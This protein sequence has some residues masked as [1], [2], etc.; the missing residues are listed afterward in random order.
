MRMRN[1]SMR[2]RARRVAAGAVAAA[3]A[4][5]LVAC[6]ANDDL[7]QQYRE[8][9]DKGFISGQFQVH[10]E[11][12][13]SRG[14][15]VVFEG[16]TEHDDPVSSDDFLGDVLVVNFWFAACG[17]CIVEAPILEDVWQ[18]NQDDDVAF[19]GINTYDQAPTALSFA[20]DH[21][22]TYPSVI[23]INDKQVSFAFAQATPIQAT[24]TTLVLDREG[25]VAARIIGQIDSASIL[26]TL[27]DGVLAESP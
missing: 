12:V 4:V 16:V 7:A 10:E 2:R 8:G 13:G 14:D 27:I 6:S 24:P 15:P 20:N 1:G 19:L 11:P 9:D 21:G 26:Q 3:L 22:V 17:P 23:D 25:R 18:A 5:T